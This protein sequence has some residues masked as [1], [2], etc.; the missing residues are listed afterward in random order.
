MAFTKRAVKVI[1]AGIYDDEYIK[2]SSLARYAFRLID[3]NRDI[4]ALLAS[5]RSGGG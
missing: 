3:Q 2:A 5:I 4:D 1:Y